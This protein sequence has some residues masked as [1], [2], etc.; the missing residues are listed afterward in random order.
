MCPTD[1]RIYVWACLFFSS[2]ASAASTCLFAV[3]RSAW[4][5][6]SS[7]LAVAFFACVKES[8]FRGGNNTKRE[9]GE[10]TRELKIKQADR[11]LVQAPVLRQRPWRPAGLLPRRPRRRP[12]PSSASSFLFR[13]R[14]PF[15]DRDG[16]SSRGGEF[17]GNKQKYDDASAPATCSI[18]ILLRGCEAQ[19]RVVSLASTGKIVNI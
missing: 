4:L 1:P 5:A 7:L 17:R 13:F 9:E 10:G 2:A 15:A 14:A 3:S 8:E 18:E 12:S 16:A 11:S 19:T 6:S